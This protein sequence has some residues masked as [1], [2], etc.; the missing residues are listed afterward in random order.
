[1]Q[2]EYTYIK[3]IIY[4]KPIKGKPSLAG[5]VLSLPHYTSFLLLATWAACAA[6]GREYGRGRGHGLVGWRERL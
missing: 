6:G 3:P 2:L 4:A 1:M 5:Y